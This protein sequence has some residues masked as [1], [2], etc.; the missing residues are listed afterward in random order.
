MAF[1]IDPWLRLRRAIH[2]GDALLVR[3]ILRTHPSLIHN[4]DDTANSSLH[5]AARLG[6]VDIVEA[7]VHLGHEEPCPALNEEHQ[8]AL[9]LA[10]AAGHTEIV[11]FLAEHDPSSILRSDLGRKDAIMYAAEGGHDTVVQLLLTYVPGGAQKALQRSNIE[12][13][14]ALHFAS[15][16]AKM[17]VVRTLLAAGADPEKRN[18]WSW[19]PGAYSATVQA[20][21]YL[22]NLVGEAERRKALLRE[23]ESRGAKGASVRMVDPDT[24]ESK[25]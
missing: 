13:N 3:R 1:R 7:L 12:G 24:D 18:A 17:P 19:T 16:H 14:T 21:V 9:M 8:T 10:A 23:I 11:H 5:I 2:A 22:K 25:K 4:P 20:E 6:H 15:A